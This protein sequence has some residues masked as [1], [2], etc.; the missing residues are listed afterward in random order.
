MEA[1]KSW[2]NLSIEEV[3][4]TLKTESNGLNKNEVSQ[5]QKRYGPNKL[6]EKKGDSYAVI[7]LR[8]FLSPLIYILIFATI[9]M[10]WL[11]EY[12]DAGVIFFVL[13]LN[14]IIG[15]IQEGRAQNAMRALKKME[16]METMVI[17]EGKELIIPASL[18]VPGDVILIQDGD[19]IPADAR[20][21]KTTSLLINESALTGE[22]TSVEKT[23]AVL[24]KTKVTVGDQNNMIFKGT[25][26]ARGHGLAVVVATGV[27]TEVGKISTELINLDGDMPLKQKIKDLTRLIIWTVG[28]MLVVFFGLGLIN[29]YS[30]AHMFIISVAVAVSVIPEGLPIVLTLVLAAG[31]WRMGQKNALV[32]KL[33][34][35]EALGQA[36]ILAMDKTGTITKNELMV[37]QLYVDGERY[38]VT[39]NGYERNGEI[40]KASQAIDVFSQPNILQLARLAIYLADAQTFFQAKE[41]IWKVVGDPTE[42]A[43]LVFAEKIGLVKS[44]IEITES[45]LDEIPFNTKLKY[46]ASLHRG[47]NQ[48][49]LA[50]IGAPEAILSLVKFQQVN[51]EIKGLSEADLIKLNEEVVHMSAQGLRVLA[52]GYRQTQAIDITESDVEDLVFAG[53]LGLKDVVRPEAKEVIGQIIEAGIRPVM[54]TGDHRITAQAIATE[55]GIFRTGDKIIEGYQLDEVAE[56]DLAKL[57]K[58]VTVFARVSPK[59]KLKI[60]QAF[61]SRGEVVAMTGDGVN[62]ALPLVAADLG[63]AMGKIGTDVAKES[64]DIV[65]LDDNLHSIVEAVKEGRNIYLTI[66]KVVL[67]MLSTGLG[68][69]LAIA[70][71]VGIGW[72]LPLIAVQIIWL[73]F[74]TDGFL[75]LALA[76]DPQAK[77]I[78]QEP[79]ADLNLL[80]RHNIFRLGLMGGVMTLGTLFLFGKYLPIEAILDHS[81]NDLPDLIKAQTIALTALAVFQWFNIWNCRDKV[82]SIFRTNP[83]SNLYLLGATIVVIG[84][85]LAIIYV[86]WLQNIFK[87]T[88]LTLVDWILILTV[89]LSIVLVEEIRKLGARYWAKFR[90]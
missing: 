79:V 67:Y 72:P 70:F 29:D 47:Q 36:T 64:G 88:A 32:K 18:L 84:L 78:L 12:V 61:K 50:L 49:K 19:Q 28:L 23:I 87:T 53:F 24:T 42:A 74:V 11:G 26:V 56:K 59:H 27:L 7:F 34:A 33:Q 13:F 77:N 85:H 9:I 8:Q 54:I 66:K 89:G 30:L 5:R 58:N 37:S 57:V 22:S 48:N 16:P 31:M 82:K 73:N 68:E 10:L 81:L 51:G 40:I 17:R 69:M 45:R 60:I 39:G 41:K 3:F 71:A 63:I 76:V 21:F 15:S 80:D 90:V 75:V 44:S 4:E 1:N 86:P 52:G 38:Q 65:L 55:V 6:E 83:L 62:D 35:V 46:H 20:L 14:A 43:L 25:Y 2:F